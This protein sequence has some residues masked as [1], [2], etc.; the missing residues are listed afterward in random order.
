MSNHLVVPGEV[1]EYAKF[2]QVFSW[3]VTYMNTLSS[4]NYLLDCKR[5]YFLIAF[6][7]MSDSA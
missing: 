6:A 3:S 4:R 1:C 5:T 2:L 7:L